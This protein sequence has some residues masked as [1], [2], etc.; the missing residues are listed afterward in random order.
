MNSDST[1]FKYPSTK[2]NEG[3]V[4]RKPTARIFVWRHP[5]AV[6][7]LKIIFGLDADSTSLR[8]QTV[9]RTVYRMHAFLAL[10]S[11]CC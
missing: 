3:K 7:L 11:D 9:K 10:S 4:S 6:W 2:Q 1:L 5:T 8:E